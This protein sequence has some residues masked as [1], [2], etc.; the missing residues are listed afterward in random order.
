MLLR[1]GTNSVVNPMMLLLRNADSLNLSGRQ[2][3]S[4]ATLNRRYLIQ[5]NRIW[6]PVSSFY[7]SRMDPA[8]PM[9]A[10][11]GPDP[12]RATVEALA[13]IVPEVEAVLTPDQRGRLSPAIAAYLDARTLTALARSSPNGVILAIDQLNSI[14]GRGRG[15]G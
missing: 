13:A 1:F 3:D 5:L 11:P 7:V 14:R 4:I 10:P 8:A 6:A 12:T 2:A 9:L 15:G